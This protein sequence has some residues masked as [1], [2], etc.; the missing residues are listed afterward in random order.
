[1]LSAGGW[2]DGVTTAKRLPRTRSEVRKS[3]G[4]GCL[5]GSTDGRDPG[6]PGLASIACSALPVAPPTAVLLSAVCSVVPA[7]Y[8]QVWCRLEGVDVEL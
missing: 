6:P 4:T 5:R 2:E 1:M 8:V 3:R 7:R